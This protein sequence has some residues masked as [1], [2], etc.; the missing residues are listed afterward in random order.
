MCDSLSAS[1]SVRESPMERTFLQRSW[2]TLLH[3][4]KTSRA[5][6]AP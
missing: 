5:H 6:V 2:D 4:L 3:V 1:C